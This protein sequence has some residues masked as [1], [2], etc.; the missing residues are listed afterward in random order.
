[1]KKVVHLSQEEYD[2]LKEFSDILTK[3]DF[4]ASQSGYE[5]VLFPKIAALICHKR[6]WI[7]KANELS[8]IYDEEDL[9]ESLEWM[10]KEYNK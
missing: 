7:D 6:Y 9:L 1:M 8:P 4:I 3:I 5:E 2:M 10:V